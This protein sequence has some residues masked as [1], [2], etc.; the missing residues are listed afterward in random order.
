MSK[1]LLM[2]TSTEVCSV[3]VSEK[4]EV[5]FTKESHD[6]N[7]H[8]E[9]LT[10]YI[11][12]VMKTVN[13]TYRELDAIAVSDGPG[14]YTS[15]RI[16]AATAKALCYAA[17]CPLITIDSLT[18]LCQGVSNLLINKG[19]VIVSMIDA[20]R[21]EVYLSIFT[22][23]KIPLI[24]KQAAIIHENLF[25]DYLTK[26]NKI[27]ICGSGAQKYLDNFG[28]AQVVVSHHATSS[29]FMA[30]LAYQKYLLQNY[31]D[32]AYFSPDYLKNPNITLSKKKLF[33]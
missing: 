9:L 33:E 24:E 32:V 13:W 18:L 12:E 25:E 29:Q 1:I 2:E 27:Y 26:T 16:G 6:K 17:D 22:S 31:N 7:S 15:L 20:R 14:S 8:T 23:E 11:S 19:D 4:G 3:S 5:L 28:T 30:T 10:L 21:M